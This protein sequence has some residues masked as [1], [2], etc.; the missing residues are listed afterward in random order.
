M[1]T[2]AAP[3]WIFDVDPHAIWWGN[4][5]AQTFWKTRSLEELK[6]RDFSSDSATVRQRLRQLVVDQDAC[7]HL[8]ETWT[9]YPAEEPVA[10]TVRFR[11]VLIEKGRSALLVEITSQRDI[12]LDIHSA[13]IEE[14]VRYSGIILSM[15]SLSGALLAQN[16]ASFDCYGS[17]RE[18]SRDLVHRLDDKGTAQA[19]FD[20][21]RRSDVFEAEIEVRTKSANKTH[22]LIAH[23]GRDPATGDIVAVLSEHDISDL[24]LLRRQ[25]SEL[26]SNLEER[27]AERSAS[28]QI[29]E[30]RFSLAMRG[31]NDGLWDNNLETG[32]VYF[33][34][35]W[36][37]MLGYGSEDPAPDLDTFLLLVHPDDRE[38]LHSAVSP[39]NLDETKAAE[40]EFRIQHKDGHWVDILSRAFLTIKDG[41][42]ARIV[43]THIDIS[44]RKHSERMLR[45]LRDILI[46][47]SE[48][49]PVGVA[50]YDQDFKLVMC[51]TLYKAMLPVSAHL[52]VRGVHFEDILRNS[53]AYMAGQFGYDNPEEYVQ[54][55]IRA[56]RV[57][58]QR[59]VHEQSSGRTVVGTEIPT[60]GNGVISII[61]DITEERA[62]QKQLQQAQKMEA[63]GQLTGGVAHDF[64]NLL[65][66]IMGNLELL[67]S[68]FEA[69]TFDIAEAEA[70]ID[71]AIGAVRH[72][73]DLT[74]SMLAYARKARLDPTVLDPNQAVQETERWM[75]RTIQSNV[76]I[77]TVL[78]GGIWSIRV[79]RNSLQ[80]AL[81][82]LILNAR[83]SM[84]GGGKL[85]IETANLRIDDTYFDS[86]DETITPGRYVMVAVSD[87]GRGIAPDV[88]DQIY[89]PFFTTKSV[90]KGTGLGLSMVEGFVR[91]SGGTVR[92][93]SEL[94][95]GTSFKL[96][97]R[98]VTQDSAKT[99]EESS[100]AGVPQEF[101][102]VRPRILLA[103]DKPEVMAVLEK[104]LVAAGYDVTTAKS[105]D[106][107][108]LIFEEDTG[109]NLVLTDIVM[110][111]RLQGPDLAKECR[112]LRPTV[113]FI[114]LSGYASEST[115]HGN[116]LSPDDVRL[117]KPV[118][119]SDLLLAVETC[120]KLGHKQ[121]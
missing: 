95:K 111:G 81:V 74:S 35:R 18:D 16:A 94:G 43:G 20:A 9:L 19:L 14:A 61:E 107:A 104:T 44:E 77:E 120:L 85:T 113:P 32:E 7:E 52:V 56:A 28:L 63:I 23:K 36:L 6:E 89:D 71:A 106:I 79:D 98:A 62:R 39:Q 8:D 118:S 93:Y 105:G 27:V 64:N 37:E 69:Q 10:A 90:G 40:V 84:E 112:L 117:M 91:Q 13:R 1:E 70:L 15:F 42:V 121:S 45:R 75:R 26:N 110:P 97:F 21:V 2:L 46:E 68:E 72:G 5:A 60:T 25:L 17:A 22:R 55:R 119:R 116:G 59:W 103:E 87:V 29:S 4:A 47:G 41:R 30:E 83:D 34:P 66:V 114:F 31:A 54:E 82:N 96:Y 33:S 101:T 49:L 88:I 102:E 78:Q 57:E 48:A 99:H 51:N 3:I 11:S 67:Q 86:R 73:A 109:F 76:E 65:A 24:V 58:R 50:Y 38:L 115:V 92:V 100:L 12:G 108:Y 80:N 53:A